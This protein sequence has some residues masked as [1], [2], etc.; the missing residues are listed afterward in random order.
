MRTKPAI[1][2]WTGA[3]VKDFQPDPGNDGIAYV[4]Y[5]VTNP[6]PG[7]WHYEYVDL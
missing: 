5:K 7:V 3:T 4:G 6:S 2:A 1:I